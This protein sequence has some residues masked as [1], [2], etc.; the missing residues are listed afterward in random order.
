MGEGDREGSCAGG[1]EGMVVE[2]RRGLHN[3]PIS[4]VSAKDR[5][6]GERTLGMFLFV[7]N[8]ISFLSARSSLGST[9]LTTTSH[10]SYSPADLT[11][12]VRAS[13]FA[14]PLLTAHSP[15]PLPSRPAIRLRRSL[16]ARSTRPIFSLSFFTTVPAEGTTRP[17]R[18][19]TEE[20]AARMRSDL[21]GLLKEAPLRRRPEAGLEEVSAWRRVWRTEEEPTVSTWKRS[22]EVEGRFEGG[23]LFLLLRLT[24]PIVTV[25]WAVA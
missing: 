4:I 10:A 22:S 19:G 25:A 24:F 11:A 17:V 16:V 18:A 23:A 5:N 12:S 1:E 20:R 3:R 13:S 14:P 6:S 2:S 8:A 9:F 7:F 21:R 15:V